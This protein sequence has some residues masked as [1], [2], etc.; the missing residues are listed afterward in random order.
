MLT[1]LELCLESY[2]VIHISDASRVLGIPIRPLL[3]YGEAPHD[4]SV[5]YCVLNV[6]FVYCIDYLYLL[7][8]VI[9]LFIVISLVRLT[10]VN[11]AK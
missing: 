5:L 4:V 9:K 11:E 7:K 8:M 1:T 10:R 3:I 6:V 2:G